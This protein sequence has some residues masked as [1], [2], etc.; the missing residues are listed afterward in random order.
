MIHDLSVLLDL[1]GSQ[2][3]GKDRPETIREMP[4][5][6]SCVFEFVVKDIQPT[7]SMALSVIVSDAEGRKYRGGTT[8]IGELVD[9]RPKDGTQYLHDQSGQQIELFFPKWCNRGVSRWKKDEHIGCQGHLHGWDTT[10]NRYQLLVT[11][12]PFFSLT[13]TLLTY[14]IAAVFVWWWFYPLWLVHKLV[15][16]AIPVGLTV[17]AVAAGQGNGELAENALTMVLVVAPLGLMLR[18]YVWA[19]TLSDRV[20]KSE[21]S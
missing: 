7:H 16:V 3:T 4:E 17:W 13:G 11:K 2:T 1:L 14:L 15:Y 10:D 20:Q 21:Q 6:D 8:V 5:K 9:D 12:V 19:V 18:F